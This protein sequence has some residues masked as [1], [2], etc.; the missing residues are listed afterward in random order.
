[1]KKVLF[2]STAMLLLTAVFTACK[3]GENDPFLS[4]RSRKARISGE[5]NLDYAEYVRISQLD[6]VVSNYGISFYDQ[7]EVTTTSTIVS[8]VTLNHEISSSPC[9]VK[10]TIE[11]DGTY[12]QVK[13]KNDEVTT[14]K[15]TWIFLKK[16]GENDLKN[17]EAILLTQS[18]MT[19]SSGTTTTEGIAGEV[20]TI[21]KLRNKEMVWKIHSETKSGSSSELVE[22]LFEFSQN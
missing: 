5:W 22:G 1:M 15:G 16:N 11:K 4:L 2:L 6:N 13:T 19:D 17:K 10:L 14:T 21:D 12:T 7:T 18:S 20:Y 3:K 9:T 8:G